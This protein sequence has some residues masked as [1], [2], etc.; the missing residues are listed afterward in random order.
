MKLQSIVALF[1]ITI[2]TA[3][4][5]TPV[6][7]STATALPPSPTIKPASTKISQPTQTSIPSPTFT[8]VPSERLEGDN[9]SGTYKVDRTD[10]GECVIKVILEPLTPIEQISFELF[11]IR[12]A[13]S[14]NSGGALGKLLFGHNMAVYAPNRSCNIVLE[15]R[16]DEIEVT[17]IGLDFDCGFGHTV[18]ADGIYK[19]IDNKPPVIGCMRQDNPCGLPVPIP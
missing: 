7:I 11:C 15:F 2:L 6:K 13:P 5:T 14:Y 1:S 3:C 9:I 4:A 19:L 12:G 18:Y 17:Q 8:S 10:G 16:N